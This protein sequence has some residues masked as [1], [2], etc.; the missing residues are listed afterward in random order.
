MICRIFAER[1]RRR[2]RQARRPETP[3]EGRRSRRSRSP[4]IR[5]WARA[6]RQHSRTMSSLRSRHSRTASAGTTKRA[7]D[8]NA[9]IPA[10]RLL[11]CSAVIFRA[12]S[13]ASSLAPLRPAALI[14]RIFAESAS[15]HARPSAGARAARRR[16]PGRGLFPSASRRLPCIGRSHIVERLQADPLAGTQAAPRRSDAIEKARIVLEGRVRNHAPGQGGRRRAA[17]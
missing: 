5:C 9:A 12:A 1:R 16:T 6:A 10:T 14:C 4:V 8:T 11:N 13:S 17:A 2:R 3:A 15:R 7:S